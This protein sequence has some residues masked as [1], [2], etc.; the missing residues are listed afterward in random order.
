MVVDK[1][2]AIESNECIYD[3]L[4][5]T[6]VGGICLLE[7]RERGLVVLRGGSRGVWGLPR[8]IQCCSCGEVTWSEVEAKWM[9]GSKEGIQ[10]PRPEEEVGFEEMWLRSMRLE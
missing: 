9:G 7:F 5:V 10:G 3:G 4:F 6:L 1:Y 2:G 8:G